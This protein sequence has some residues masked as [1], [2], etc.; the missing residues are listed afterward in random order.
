MQR[1]AVGVGDAEVV[2]DVL[3]ERRAEV[4]ATDQHQHPHER[5]PAMVSGDAGTEAPEQRETARV[6][7]VSGGVTAV[8][9]HGVLLVAVVGGVRR[10]HLHRPVPPDP[11]HTP[12]RLIPQITAA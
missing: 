6:V 9:V 10:P 7:V 4:A 5:D 3:L 1:L 12:V 8:T 11:E 2:G